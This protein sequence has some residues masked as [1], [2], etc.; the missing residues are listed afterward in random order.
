M[1]TRSKKTVQVL[2]EYRSNYQ[3]YATT[4]DNVKS[5]MA[6]NED[7]YEKIGL[8]YED[9]VQILEHLVKAQHKEIEKSN[10]I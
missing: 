7:T 8:V 1:M 10:S 4:L 3:G 2:A 5:R 6:Q 9:K